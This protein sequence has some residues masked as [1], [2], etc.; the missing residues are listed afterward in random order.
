MPISLKEFKSGKKKERKVVIKKS[1]M[2]GVV[3]LTD[4]PFDS[5]RQELWSTAQM[6]IDDPSTNLVEIAV[7]KFLPT[8]L[9]Q[10]AVDCLKK[11]HAVK[12]QR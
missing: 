7:K 6:I 10:E 1:R 12:N 11:K 4:D 8:V 2:D 9:L 5:L 3:K